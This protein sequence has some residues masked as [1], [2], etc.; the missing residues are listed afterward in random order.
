MGPPRRPSTAFRTWP[1]GGPAAGRGPGVS[2][3]RPSAYPGRRHAVRTTHPHRRALPSRHDRSE[4]HCRR[5]RGRARRV[6]RPRHRLRGDHRTAPAPEGLTDSK[7]L[8]PKRRTALAAM[9]ESWV[10]AYALGHA[11]PEEIDDLGMTAALRLAAVRALEALPVR[12]DAVILDGKHDYLGHALAGP[13]GDQGRPVLR[14]RRGGLG[15][16]QGSARQNDG[17]T[18][19]RHMQT[20]VLRPT[21]GIR[22]RCTR[23]RWRSGAPPRT[24]GCR[25]RILMRCPSGGTSRRPA[26][27]RTEAFRRSRASSASTSDR[28]PLA[29]M[30][31]PPTRLAPAFDRNQLMPLIP[32]EPQIH[33]SAQGPRVTPASGRTA[34][35]PRPVPGPRPAAPPRPGRPGPRRPTPPAQRTPH[36]VG[37]SPQRRAVARPLPPLPRGRRS[38]RLRRSS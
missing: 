5:R 23:P 15:D 26:A 30:C 37:R 18:G 13:Y 11:S 38:P 29:L 24:T 14:G 16:R 28:I 27:G 7:L 25:G 33:E 20:S 9:L 35:T 19:H 36:D 21:P 2:L 17:R 31:H 3:P 10:T 12:P 6:G 1:S 4:D 34:P 32:E 8:S 22:R